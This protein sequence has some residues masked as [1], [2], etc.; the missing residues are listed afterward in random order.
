M[1]T[2]A[3]LK[4]MLRSPVKTAVTFLL[5]TAVTFFFVFNLAG[6]AAQ[7]KTAKQVEKNTFGVLT[8]EY[9]PAKTL[10]EPAYNF[11]LL[12][13]PTDPGMDYGQLTYESLHQKPLS[14][15]DAAALEALPYVDGVDR[16]YMTAGVSEEYLRLDD[17]PAWYGYQDRCILEGT[18]VSN[19]INE[20]MVRIYGLN[21]DSELSYTEVRYAPDGIHDVFLTDVKLLTGDPDWLDL[22]LSTYGG[23]V[24]LLICAMR[25][26]Y[27]GKLGSHIQTT[28][29]GRV[30]VSCAD[31][32]LSLDELQSI[33]P[34]RRYVFVLRESPGNTNT[35]LQ[36]MFRYSMGDDSRK[37]W[38]PYFADITGQPEDYLETEDYAGLRSLI[39]VSEAD[40]HTFDVVYT[41][42]MASIRRVTQ[43]QLTAVQGRFLT[44][45]DAGSAVCVV[46]EALLE[47]TGLRPGDSLRL[48][49]GNVLME[50]YAPLGAVAVTKGR[51]AS[52]WTERSFTVVG[53]YR[54]AGDGNWLDREL[55]WAYSD[56]TVFVPSSFLPESCD[57]ENHLF[58]P[59]EISF[60]VGKAENILPFEE[61]VLPTLADRK[62]KYEFAD[63][64]WAAAAEKMR[65][66]QTASL[67]RLLA[68]GAAA[69]LAAALTVYLCLVRRKRE[70][71]ILR[72]LGCPKR[73]AAR[74]LWLPLLLSAFAAALVGT[75]L[76]GIHSGRPAQS[77]LADLTE[78][79]PGLSAAGYGLAGLGVLCLIALLCALYLRSLGK[80]SPLSLLQE[81]DR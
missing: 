70:Y 18:V 59:A 55:Y 56:N 16:R 20:E 23:Q 36:L 74:A 19:E 73:A 57:T 35:E 10:A 61:E 27:I 15:E 2:A 26:E 78:E 64:N 71:A 13:D 69:V 65:Q 34:G 52:E 9:G 14:E 25:D 40:R 38:W 48:K 80:K 53:S 50:Q 3:A 60:L 4:M 12:T 30:P 29:E 79:A 54:D 17:Y 66:A 81:K 8:A 32:D 75:V 47:R 46:S 67:T 37:G 72:A 43:E 33:T 22:Q 58:R 42:N 49:L 41:D 31:Y 76:A 68:F 24:K 77:L 62:L 6:Y 7:R 39:E 21:G 51:Y 63:R 45:A 44:P 5:L 11:F 28:H 1:K